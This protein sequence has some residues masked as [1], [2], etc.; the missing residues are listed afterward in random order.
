MR[1][2]RL[3]VQVSIADRVDVREGSTFDKNSLSRALA[4]VDTAFYLI[5][6]M[7]S[8]QNYQDLD[9]RSAENFRLACIEAGVRRIIY[10]GGLGVKE[11]AGKHLLS[12]IE[13]GEILSAESERIQTIWL[14]AGVIDSVYPDSIQARLCSGRRAEERNRTA[15]R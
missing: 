14:R 9:R 7:G 4:W 5:H 8:E 3:K 2:N 11:S 12:R 1:N 15:E 13:T 10:L 6:S